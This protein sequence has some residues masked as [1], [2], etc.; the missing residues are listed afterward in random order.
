MT[1]ALGIDTGGTFTDAV[2]LR[3]DKEVVAAAKSLTTRHDLSEGIT[4]AARA[5][6][7]AS[8]ID[9][10]DLAL[11]S[12]STTLA[13]NALVEG[14]GDRAG[15]VAIGFAPRD[16]EAAG[17]AEALSGEPFVILGG[18]H[19]HAGGQRQPLDEAGLRDW[20]AGAGAGLSAYAVAG[21]FATRNPEHEQQAA[22]IIGEVTGAPVSSS[23]M[24]S[25]RLNGP[26]RGLTALLNARLIGMIDRLIVAAQGGLAALGILAPLMV[27]RG[28]GALIAADVARERPIETILSG[29]AASL[30]GARWLTGAADAIVADIGGTTTDVG[31][32]RGGRPAI[33]LDG[34]RVGGFR[35]M[36]EAVAMRTTGLGGDSEVHMNTGG[37]S[38][39]VTLGPRRL[40]P[41]S[42]IAQ[43]APD[44]VR[45]AL[46]AATSAPVPS[47]NEGR[48]VRA[49]GGAEAR[50][51]SDREA[52]LLDRIGDA[53][54][55]LG[56]ILRQRIEAQ[57]LKR[58]VGRGFV[59]IAG[60][61]PTDA[62]HV[63]G[64]TDAWDAEAA[65]A[66]LTLLARRRTGA[67][68][69]LASSAE[70]LAEMIVRQLQRQA[71]LALLECAFAE[72]DGF[73]TASE[74]LARHELTQKGLGSGHRG[75]V[76]I[77]A[78]LAIDAIGLGASA[79]TYFGAVG[80][81]LGCAMHLPEHAGVANAIGA[82]VGRVAVRRRGTLTVRGEGRY[83]LHLDSGPE[84]FSDEAEALARLEAVLSGTVR[85]DALA[86]GAG[87]VTLH[88]TRDL[89]RAE[90][91]G[92]EMLIEATVTVEATGRPRTAT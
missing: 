17:L 2:I 58:L 80:D 47:E 10:S 44:V 77:E 14:Q 72:D 84:D 79:P 16:L 57:A 70:A 55:P 32:L 75:L 54:H 67:G 36:V 83:R 18:G 13:T 87:D 62:V 52:A 78:G 85:D 41:V 82:V 43:Q 40:V 76:R 74:T 15:L 92:R 64:L 38:G 71:S 89:R 73:E 12:L 81:R 53:V 61:T 6:L 3:D 33:D 29:P 56:A 42:L 11:S 69:P 31:L 35:T 86:A 5:V 1:L 30:V 9:G 60:V 20:L 88:C 51:L 21:Q 27:V 90:I 68:M 8:G 26:K 4:A 45:A 24:L 66:A 34:A 49:V 91:E 22:R 59:Q 37:L 65:R 50:G 23:H 25:A 7:E 48:F 63:L 46:E 19:D 39:G 28:D